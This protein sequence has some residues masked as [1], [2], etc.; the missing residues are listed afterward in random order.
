V[1][2]ACWSW[3]GLP[4]A[5]AQLVVTLQMQVVAAAVYTAGVHTQL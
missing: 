4:G 1:S 3:Q 5:F 2:L